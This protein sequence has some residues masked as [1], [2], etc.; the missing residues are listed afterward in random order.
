MNKKD[1]RF[2]RLEL[3]FVMNWSE[4]MMNMGFLVQGK[5]IFSIII[6]TKSWRLSWEIVKNICVCYAA[7]IEMIS[8]KNKCLNTTEL[9]MPSSISCNWNRKTTL[10]YKNI[11]IFCSLWWKR[12]RKAVPTFIKVTIKSWNAMARFISLWNPHT[13]RTLTSLRKE[14]NLKVGLNITN[15]TKLCEN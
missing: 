3:C 2:R 4:H 6:W 9:I 12:L 15:I 10:G 1:L 8:Y 14:W 7:R 13:L 11:F 5:E